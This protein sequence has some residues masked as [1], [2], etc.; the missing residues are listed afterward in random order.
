[1]H[2]QYRSNI[3]V[4]INKPSLLKNKSLTNK[5]GYNKTTQNKQ[6]RC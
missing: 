3:A 6:T 4:Y 1:M 2:T 5:K